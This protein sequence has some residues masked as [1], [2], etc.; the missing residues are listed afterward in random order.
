MK[1]KK[2]LALKKSFKEKELYE[3]FCEDED[4]EMAMLVKRYKKHACQGDQWMGIG[5]RNFR[6]D[7][8]RNELS[9]NNQITC[10]DCK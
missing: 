10:Y 1:K 8:F 6:K 3:T 5:R 7:W 9:R 4:A 2:G